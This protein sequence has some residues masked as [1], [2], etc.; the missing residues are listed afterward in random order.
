MVLYQHFV[1]GYMQIENKEK[2][3]K[4]YRRR[5]PYNKNFKAKNEVSLVDSDPSDLE[6]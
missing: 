4:S 3:A 5:V 6:D 2:E 1:S